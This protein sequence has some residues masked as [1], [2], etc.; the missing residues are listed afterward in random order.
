MRLL[1]AL[2]L[3]MLYSFS[4]SSNIIIHR[5]QYSPIYRYRS[6]TLLPS[7]SS[8]FEINSKNIQLFAQA[9]RNS[10]RNGHALQKSF[11]IDYVSRTTLPVIILNIH[12]NVKYQIESNIACCKRDFLNKHLG[13]SHMKCIQ[14]CIVIKTFYKNHQLIRK[15]VYLDT[16][17]SKMNDQMSVSRRILVVI[18]SSS[19]ADIMVAVDGIPLIKRSTTKWMKTTMTT[20]GET[21]NRTI[22][23]DV[24][25]IIVQGIGILHSIAIRIHWKVVETL[26][27]LTEV[28][29]GSNYAQQRR[30]DWWG[31]PSN[32]TGKSP[33]TAVVLSPLTNQSI[34]YGVDMQ[35]RVAVTSTI[36]SQHL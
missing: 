20:T 24:P 10:N 2:L 19:T 23:N 22:S 36:N 8:T 6:D 25:K 11:E 15:D 30:W 29:L 27:L 21:N 7:P 17:G 26:K 9:I 13:Y 3:C 34:Q 4:F 28:H 35:I 16:V 31:I 5:S 33:F 12:Y 14:K 32:S 1:N 18:P